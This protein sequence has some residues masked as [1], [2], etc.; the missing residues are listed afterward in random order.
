GH[1]GPSIDLRCCILPDVHR[2]IAAGTSK[3]GLNAK[4]RGYRW[5]SRSVRYSRVRY[6]A[7][8]K[9]ERQHSNNKRESS[10]S[11]GRLMTRHEPPSR[12]TLHALFA[13]PLSANVDFKKVIHLLE[14][15][16][17]RLT[18]SLAIESV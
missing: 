8:G 3:Y 14:D 6:S 17:Q 13:H 16:G 10:L 11:C 2:R 15:L 7:F 4:G 9:I 1:R 5:T 12:K 18:I